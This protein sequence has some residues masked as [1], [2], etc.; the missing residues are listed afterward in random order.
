MLWEQVSAGTVQCCRQLWQ[1]GFEAYPV[2]GCV[3]DL[4]LGRTPGDW[5]VTTGARPEQVMGLFDYVI[6][7]GVKHGTITV[8]LG[9]ETI[10]VTTFRGESG[11]S[12]SRH[13]DAVRFDVS[14][15]EDLSR[16]DFTVNAMALAPDGTV[17]D[18][19]GG[20]KDLKEK[21][22]RCVGR[23]EQ[24]FFED[25]LRMFRAVRFAAQL[26]FEPDEETSR[27]ISQCAAGAGRISAERV[28][29]ELEKTVC[30]PR[31]GQVSRFFEFGLMAGMTKAVPGSLDALE[32]LPAGRLSR[33]AGLCAGLLRDGCID[34]AAV[35]LKGLRLDGGIV[36]ACRAG[37]MLWRSGLPAN[38]VDW[39]KALA[40]FGT[41]GCEAAAAMAVMCG[42][43]SAPEELERVLAQKPCI[44]PKDLALSGGQLEQLGL[45]GLQIGA[46]QR[47]LLQHVLE[48]PRENREDILREKLAEYLG[49]KQ[50]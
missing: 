32:Q 39:R 19:F 28:C 3:R 5:D 49:Q 36:R 22:I 42:Q 33:W 24:R 29:V 20:Q 44:S 40:E 37:E 12:D 11:Y 48:H 21:R 23:P 9:E 16:R 47:F 46:A 14:L 31:P 25:G 41:S 2:G 45:R 27:A 50:P 1:A 13:P 18:L 7:T 26:G 4:L 15:E 35:F 17:V 30:S 10:E 38:E 6:A 8:I 43:G 34:S